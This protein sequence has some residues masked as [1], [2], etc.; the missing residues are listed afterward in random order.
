MF[1]VLVAVPKNFT[2]LFVANHYGVFVSN[3]PYIRGSCLTHDIVKEH[4]AKAIS[5]PLSFVNL[6]WKSG[7]CNKHDIYCT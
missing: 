4:L 3:N 5:M 2:F 1:S 6:R 7:T